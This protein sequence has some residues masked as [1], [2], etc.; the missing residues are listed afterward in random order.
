[1]FYHQLT[2]VLCLAL[3]LLVLPPTDRGIVPSI[4]PGCS[5]TCRPQGLLV[6]PPPDR[7]IVLSNRL[8]CFTTTDLKVCLFYHLLTAK[9]LLVLPPTD[10]K[11]C[12][13]YHLLTARPACFTT[14][15][16]QYCAKQ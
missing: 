3:G 4:K 16:P 7:N 5:T 6:L 8:A 11:A 13:F 9:G 1:V 12:L 10:G 14:Y 2:A 15:G